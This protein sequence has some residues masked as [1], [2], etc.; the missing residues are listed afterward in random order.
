MPEETTPQPATPNS[1]EQTTPSESLLG[2]TETTTE[3]PAPQTETKPSENTEEKPKTEEGAPEKYEF[4]PLE[5]RQL[6]P[7]FIKAYSETAK[8]LNLPQEKAQKL[9]D[10]MGPVIE[11]RQ[12]E[13]INAVRS[14]WENSSKTDAEFG[15]AKL[16]ENLGVAR[17][18]LDQFGTPELRELLNA[19]GIGNHPE[20]VRFF[21]RAG[22]ALT[23]DNF[24]GGH[25][26]AKGTP[27]TF[28]D[29]ANKLYSNS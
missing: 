20:V 5:G 19:S 6:D 18:A 16:E 9:L 25:K 29:M 8:E 23:S 4:K 7:E 2:K 14:Q 3:Q 27:R 10:K 24:V 15:G 26:E 11:A 1:G 21:Y 17:K 12:L 13:Q 22:K 28:N